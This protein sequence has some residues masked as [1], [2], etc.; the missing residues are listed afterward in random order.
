[1]DD[2]LSININD[3]LSN[4]PAETK[5]DKNELIEALKNSEK[6]KYEE[7]T[8]IIKNQLKPRMRIIVFREIPRECQSMENIVELLT[9]EHMKKVEKIETSRGSYYVYLKDEKDAMEVYEHVEEMRLV[10][11]II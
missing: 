5:P 4:L 11:I 10:N 7:N 2:F 9:E 1:M 3:Y 6:Y 8:N